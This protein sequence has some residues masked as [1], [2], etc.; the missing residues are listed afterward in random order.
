MRQIG[1]GGDPFETGSARP[2]DFGHWAAHRL[3]SLTRYHL[4]HGEAV[5]IGMALDTRYSVLG[6]LARRRRRR[7]ASASCSTI[8][9]SASG[10][11]RWKRPARTASPPSCRDCAS[12]VS[13]WAAS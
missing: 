1:Q 10:T 8:S 11:R 6:G 2:L 13:I 5:A 12:S 7:T 3:E 4:R 9:A